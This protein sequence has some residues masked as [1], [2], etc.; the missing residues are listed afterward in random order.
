MITQAGPLAIVICDDNRDILEQ[1]ILGF[2]LQWK[3]MHDDQPEFDV[4][5]ILQAQQLPWQCQQ[6]AQTDVYTLIIALGLVE[7]AP[8]WQKTE[9]IGI[10][11][12]AILRI[13]LDSKIPILSALSCIDR[14]CQNP[15]QFEMYQQ[16][17]QQKGQDFARA[18]TMLFENIELLEE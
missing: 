12:S 16:Y 7:N 15:L 9:D 2:E 1:A 11:D 4:F 3:M 8:L 17:F 18:A 5:D 10:I 14:S 6:I 13:S